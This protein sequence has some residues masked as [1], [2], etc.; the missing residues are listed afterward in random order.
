MNGSVVFL[1]SE[2]SVLLAPLLDTITKAGVLIKAVIVSGKLSERDLRIQSRRLDPSWIIQKL[3]QLEYPFVPFHFVKKSNHPDCL[4]LLKQLEPIYLLNAGI[5]EILDQEVLSAAN[6]VINCHPGILPEY[7]GCTCVEWSIYNNDPVGA[8]AHF[9]NEKIDEGPIIKKKIMPVKPFESYEIIRSRMV[10]HQA[11]LFAEAAYICLKEKLNP[12]NFPP[13]DK[14]AYHR[15]IGQ[16]KF[17]EIK[18]KL[19]RGEY[20]SCPD[21]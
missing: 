4:K 8:T 14:G 9:M 3:R 15:H 10:F 21:A 12:H 13:Q 11:E 6:G 1:C 20:Q 16:Q 18:A 19:L 5:A 2:G 17:L 7:Q